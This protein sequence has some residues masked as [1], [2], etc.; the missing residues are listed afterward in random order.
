MPNVPSSI[1]CDPFKVLLLVLLQLS[2]VTSSF[3]IFSFFCEKSSCLHFGFDSG[4]FCM[5]ISVGAGRQGRN[6][7]WVVDGFDSTRVTEQ[8]TIKNHSMAAMALA[9]PVHLQ[10]ISMFY[11]FLHSKSVQ[12]GSNVDPTWIHVDPTSCQDSVAT[13]KEAWAVHAKYEATSDLNRVL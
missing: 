6:L 11:T 3:H 5:A 4:A 12:C 7:G 2:P 8:R 13:G 10:W 1:S 9:I